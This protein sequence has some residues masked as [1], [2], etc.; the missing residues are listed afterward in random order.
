MLKTIKELFASTTNEEAKPLADH[1]KHLACAALLI[2]VAV[3]D[4]KFDQNEFEAMQK[5]LV[6]HFNIEEK[7]CKELIDSAQQES[8]NA[9][10]TYQ[11]TQLVNQHCS[12]EDKFSL[13]KGMWC[14]AYADN[15]LDKYEEYIIRKVSGLI[16]MS[17]NDFIR[18][19]HAVKSEL[20]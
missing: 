3:I 5:I 16:H 19:K 15:D 1:E 6:E 20:K 9:S 8:S 10:S 11:F 14:I 12:I 17:H 4:Q 13:L 7:E 18:A 2:E